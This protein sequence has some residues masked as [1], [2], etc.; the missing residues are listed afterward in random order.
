M[1]RSFGA[2]GPLSREPRQVAHDKVKEF[3]RTLDRDFNELISLEELLEY[4]TKYKLA[5]EGNAS[6]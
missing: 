3:I 2:D 6:S 4:R 5:I 1:H